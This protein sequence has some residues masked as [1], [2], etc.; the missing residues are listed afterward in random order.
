MSVTDTPESEVIIEKVDQ[1]PPQEVEGEVPELDYERP[2]DAPVEEPDQGTPIEEPPVPDEPI[3]PA[4]Q[5]VLDRMDEVQRIAS[6]AQSELQRL[7]D[8]GVSRQDDIPDEPPK[9]RDQLSTAQ[10]VL[11]YVAW[12]NARRGKVERAQRMLEATAA[13]SEQHARG[14][15]SPGTMGAGYDYDSMISRHISP[16]ERINPAFRTAMREMRDPAI[17]RYGIAFFI[18]SLEKFGGDPARTFKEMRSALNGRAVAGK[19]IVQRIQQAQKSGAE[20]VRM[21]A[22]RPGA[23]SSP[24]KL[25]A[26]DISS[27][28]N[29]DFIKL[30]NQMYAKR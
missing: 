27:M 14:L 29:R 4:M 17:A 16:I 25:T 7:R 19:D 12:E 8:A 22:R 6:E 26:E 13:A 11:E 30:R 9:P 2:A 23:K 21:K 20:N 5:A 28:D 24:N 15:L 10:D 18:E 1:P 3:S